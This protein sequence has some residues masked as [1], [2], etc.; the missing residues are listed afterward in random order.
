MSEYW[1][2]IPKD[3]KNEFHVWLIG[4]PYYKFKRPEPDKHFYINS[5]PTFHNA[6]KGDVS[7]EITDGYDE[8]KDEILIT[9]T[10]KEE[11]LDEGLL[12]L[13]RENFTVLDSSCY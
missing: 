2:V 12:S 3:E 4:H 1:F 11:V 6:E 7:C 8:K 9:F 13:I 5:A 10:F